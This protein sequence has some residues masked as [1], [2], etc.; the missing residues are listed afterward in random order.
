[1]KMKKILLVALSLMLLLAFGCSHDTNNSSVTNPNPPTLFPKG[2][3][4]GKI[5]DSCTGNPIVGAVVDI[6]IAKATTNTA[7]QYVIK[8]VPATS[9]V[10]A[11]TVTGSL[12][13]G[14]SRSGDTGIIDTITG[15]LKID[16]GYRGNYSATIDMTMATVGGVKVTNYASYYYNEVSVK[17]ASMQPDTGVLSATNAKVTPVVGLGNGDFDFYLGQLTASIS[18]TVQ[19]A[20]NHAAAASYVVALYSTDNGRNG[21]S[22]SG[23]YNHLIKSA[24]TKADGTFSITGL[25]A[26]ATFNIVAVD[27]ATGTA[28]YMATKTSVS[29]ACDGSNSDVGYLFAK[30]T[31]T[32][33][34]F[35]LSVTPAVGTDVDGTK[36][37]ISV[38]FTFSKPILAT[39]RNSGQGV[40]PSPY[41]PD[42]YD[43]VWVN[44][45]GNKS[46]NIEHSLSWNTAMT[47]LTV[48]LPSGAVAPG[49]VYTV[50][51]MNNEFLADA[52]GHLLSDGPDSDGNVPCTFNS[53]IFNGGKLYGTTFSTFGVETAGAITD[54]RVVNPSA[55]LV[56]FDTA[57]GLDW[58]PV[59]GAKRYHVYCQLIQWPGEQTFPCDPSQTTGQVHPYVLVAD[60]DGTGVQFSHIPL[61]GPNSLMPNLKW[62]LLIGLTNLF[63]NSMF[64]DWYFVE[65][66][67]IKL[68][69][70]CYVRGVDLDSIEGPMPAT[71]LYIEDKVAP[72]MT[73][74]QCLS[75]TISEITVCFNEPMN[76]ATLQNVPANLTLNASAFSGTAP[77]IKSVDLFTWQGS[78]PCATITLSGPGTLITPTAATAILTVGGTVQDVSGNLLN[79]TVAGSCVVGVCQ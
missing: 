50:A 57:F 39:G 28:K 14:T 27:T 3:V 18:G 42:L 72:L 59:T 43:D 24:V 52:S 7:G 15:K 8:N 74:T 44:Y 47:Q 78:T 6:G 22:A 32:I 4:Q 36:G 11:T 45:I 31:D 51:I 5:V 54:L 73:T 63:N 30:D 49:A 68:A 2:Y 65:D 79:C 35:I 60:T 75:G 40:T 12:N 61:A 46:S 17:F 58:T 64:D 76:E 48:T 37:A 25:E 9:Y 62:E 13:S 23:F 41:W 56:D 10:D 53:N 33:C 16:S 1:M 55:D 38:V 67:G 77:T 21:N 34:P 19:M 69:Y 20:A 66:Y 29:T 26:G 71:V 70:N